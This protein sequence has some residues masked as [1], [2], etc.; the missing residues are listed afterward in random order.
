M[1][2]YPAGGN[3]TDFLS[4]NS[5]AGD[6]G[7]LSDM[8]VVTTTMRMV[9]G[10]H[11]HTTST[12]PVVT[13][14]L[15]FVVSTASLEQGLVDPSTTSDDTNSRTSVTRHGLLGTGGEADTGLVVVGGVANDGGVVSGCAG[16]GTTVAGLL[17]DVADDGTLRALAHGEDVADVQGSFFAAVDECAG[18]HAFGGD[19]GLLA[20]LVAVWVTEDDTGEGG[21]AVILWEAI[22]CE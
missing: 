17:L 7:S 9:D 21:T 20:Q 19:E 10:V 11:S 6:G 2:T 8:L 5:G 12:R 14:S 15:E 16:E 4:R 3:E 1:V 13:L 22:I 18:V